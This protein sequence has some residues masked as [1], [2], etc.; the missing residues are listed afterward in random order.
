MPKKKSIKNSAREFNESADQIL[1]FFKKTDSLKEPCPEWSADYAVIRLYIRFEVL[2]LDTLS[3]AINNDSSTIAATADMTFPKHM[4]VDVCRYFI[5]G[6]GFFDFK[7]RDGLIQIV[8]K[9]VP[10]THYLLKII[11]DPKY[12]DALEQLSAFRNLAAHYESKRAKSAAKKATGGQ[13][14]GSAGSWLRKQGR[15]EKLCESLKKFA[16]TVEKRAPY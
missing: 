2:M 16:H 10:E 12:K 4:S 3:G 6:T 8:K 11:R 15:F 5:V 13:K 7:G 1:D 9:Y 14:I